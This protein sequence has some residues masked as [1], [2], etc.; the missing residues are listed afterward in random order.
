MQQ[1]SGPG[2]AWDKEY[3]G[4][5]S[6]EDH[7]I[8]ALCK[9]RVRFGSSSKATQIFTSVFK[10]FRSGN[11]V[12]L[13]KVTRNLTNAVVLRL[14]VASI[15]ADRIKIVTKSTISFATGAVVTE[16][17]D[18]FPKPFNGLESAVHEKHCWEN[19][20]EL[21]LLQQIIA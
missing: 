19:L 11:G 15:C 4:E 5:Q 8:N 7:G 16:I 14:V 13:P 1:E 10:G 12:V 3:N 21:Q 18:F 9:F 2:R 20:F 17:R 6:L